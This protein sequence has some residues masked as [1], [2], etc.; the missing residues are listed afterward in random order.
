VWLFALLVPYQV[1]QYRTDFKKYYQLKSTQQ[2]LNIEYS[3]LL[4][5]Q[6]TFGSTP[7]I[8]A[9]AA[10]ELGMQAPA[11]Y[12][13]QTLSIAPAQAANGQPSRAP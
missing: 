1:H 11:A 2:K 10:E 7:T 4:L 5:E 13:V 8:G 3:K 6:Q 12:K 9:R